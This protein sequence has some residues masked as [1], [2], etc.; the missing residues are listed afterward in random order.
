M[1]TNPSSTFLGASNF[2]VVSG[3]AFFTGTAISPD[4]AGPN[5]FQFAVTISSTTTGFGGNIYA[6]F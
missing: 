3:A 4:T 6:F 5:T 1:R 2:G